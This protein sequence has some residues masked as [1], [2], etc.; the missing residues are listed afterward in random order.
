LAHPLDWTV[1]E[2][3][4][5]GVETVI[6]RRQTKPELTYRIPVPVY[7]FDRK[8][9]YLWK[10]FDK[11]LSYILKYKGKTIWYPMSIFIHRIILSSAVY[12]ETFALETAVAIEGLLLTEFEKLASPTAEFVTELSKASEIINTTSEIDDTLKLRI[13]S[14]IADMKKSRATDKLRALVKSEIIEKKEYEAWKKLR[15]ES[16]HPTRPAFVELQNL[17]DLSNIM[18]TLFYKLIFLIIGYEGKY[19]NYGI[20]GYPLKDFPPVEK[21]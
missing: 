19:M 12:I 3:N 15:N 11:Y 4:E 5:N 8:G 7:V 10:L 14:A 2:Q 9:E 13:C 16:T 6:I 18:I 1:L 20:D 17:L 21:D